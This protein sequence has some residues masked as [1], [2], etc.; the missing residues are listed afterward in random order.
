[1]ARPWEL[2]FCGDGC[3]IWNIDVNLDES[4]GAVDGY[5]IDEFFYSLDILVGYQNEGKEVEIS[6]LLSG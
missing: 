5:E 3:S 2:W 6:S 1:M 4:E